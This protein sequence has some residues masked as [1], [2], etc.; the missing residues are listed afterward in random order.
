MP[1]IPLP[2]LS[3][4]NPIVGI[5]LTPTLP[6][7]EITIPNI[8]CLLPGPISIDIGIVLPPLAINDAFLEPVLDA[9]ATIEAE[10]VA[11]LPLNC[12]RS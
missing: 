2:K 1:C 9:L 12:P 5:S 11:L 7:L 10:I 4:P 3:L 8:C 6:E